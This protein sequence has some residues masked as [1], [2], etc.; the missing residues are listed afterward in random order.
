MPTLGGTPRPAP[1]ADETG[2]RTPRA[3]AASD[4]PRLPERYRNRNP[5][6]LAYDK[7]LWALF[8]PFNAEGF[9]FVDEGLQWRRSKK[10]TLLALWDLERHGC[11]DE[12]LLQIATSVRND[13]PTWPPPRTIEDRRAAWELI[14]L[15]KKMSGI[16]R[17]TNS[18]KG[19]TFAP[20]PG[21]DGRASSDVVGPRERR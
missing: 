15:Y 4:F 6:D 14:D 12:C 5:Y 20:P 11:K 21:Y 10:P 18:T 2:D 13:R 9:M 3:Q 1:R 8:A 16:W 17:E 19:W 7:E